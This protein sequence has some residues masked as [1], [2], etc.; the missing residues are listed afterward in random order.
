MNKLK[1]S[2]IVFIGH[3]QLMSLRKAESLE[4]ISQKN[5]SQPQ[6]LLQLEVLAKIPKRC[7]PER[8]EGSHSY[9]SI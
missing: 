8:N 6:K 9:I 7:H 2:F 1:I 4:A 3:N 5:T